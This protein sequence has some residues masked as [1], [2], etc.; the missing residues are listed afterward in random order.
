MRNSLEVDLTGYNASIQRLMKLGEVRRRDIADVFRKADRGVVSL[1]RATAGRSAK[2]MVSKKYPSRSHPAG[3][4]KRGI[5]FAVSKKRTLVYYVRSKAWYTMAYIRG[6]GAW[7]G[8]PFM[9]RA[10]TVKEGQTKRLLEQGLNKL[11]QRAKD[12]K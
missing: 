8:N 4:L 3:A 7:G 11:I 12:G 6:H 5:G 9:E 2:G 1:A 10:V